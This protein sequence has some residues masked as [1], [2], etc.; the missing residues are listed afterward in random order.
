MVLSV[1]AKK[2][3]PGR[4][5]AY[6]DNGREKTGLDVVEWVRRGV[7]LGAGEVFVTSVDRDGTRQGFDL[8]LIE[9]VTRNVPVPIIVGG[10]L[11][12]AEDL[13]KVT[14]GGCVDAVAVGSALHHSSVSLPQLR[15]AAMSAGVKMR[16]P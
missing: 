13:V 2:V 15:Q 6:V 7:E 9:A 12:S 16:M 14:K 5:E 4:W 8:E 3:A 10:G 11:G 1:E